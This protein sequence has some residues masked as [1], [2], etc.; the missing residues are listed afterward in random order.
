[1]KKGG[2]THER[3]K[4]LFVFSFSWIHS[5]LQ[6]RKIP[7]KLL[8]VVIMILQ[9]RRLRKGSGNVILFYLLLSSFYFFFFFF[10]YFIYLFCFH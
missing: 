3:D 6:S 2:G 8:L 1:V 4:G 5:W 7:V 9:K 10:F